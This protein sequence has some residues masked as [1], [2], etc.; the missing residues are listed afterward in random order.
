VKGFLKMRWQH[1]SIMLLSDVYSLSF[2]KTRSQLLIVHTENPTDFP[3]GQSTK[4]LRLRIKILRERFSSL[5]QKRLQY[6]CVKPVPQPRAILSNYNN[7]KLVSL[8]AWNLTYNMSLA[9]AI[10]FYKECWVRSTWGQEDTCFDYGPN[11]S[12]KDEGLM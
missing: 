3:S 5:N 11:P 1:T 6:S 4:R 2:Y 9:N 7:S 12:T 10:L 8:I